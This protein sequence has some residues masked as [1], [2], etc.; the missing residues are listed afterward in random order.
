VKAFL[1]EI[2]TSVELSSTVYFPYFWLGMKQGHPASHGMPLELPLHIH[3][4]TN[5]GTLEI[6]YH[7]TNIRMFAEPSVHYF[8]QMQ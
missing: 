2:H 4:L 3:H 6:Y 1:Q 8:E 7:C 5:S